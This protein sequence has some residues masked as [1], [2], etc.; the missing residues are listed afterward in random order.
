MSLDGETKM[1][2]NFADVYQKLINPPHCS[3]TCVAA[4]LD[5][6]R[7]TRTAVKQESAHKGCASLPPCTEVF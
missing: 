5:D 2:A 1:L 7:N 6:V 3:E 4:G